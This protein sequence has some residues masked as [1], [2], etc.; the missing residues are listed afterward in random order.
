MDNVN[1]TEIIFKIKLEEDAKAM[2][3]ILAMNGYKVSVCPE[4]DG[5]DKRVCVEVNLNQKN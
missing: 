5:Y 4:V 2:A 3:S 1:L